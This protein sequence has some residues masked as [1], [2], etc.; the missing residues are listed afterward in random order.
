MDKE[1]KEVGSFQKE[2]KAPMSPEEQK[3][4]V[5]N[6]IAGIFSGGR[7][8]EAVIVVA[9]YSEE[10]HPNFT[11]AMAGSMPDIL[12]LGRAAV[13]EIPDSIAK[14]GISQITG[15]PIDEVSKRV[16]KLKAEEAEKAAEAKKADPAKEAVIQAAAIGAGLGGLKL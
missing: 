13:V 16:D 9:G 4:V 11:I 10:A 12:A 15:M 7:I 3:A 6:A 1:G 5:E 8:P 2:I 14:A